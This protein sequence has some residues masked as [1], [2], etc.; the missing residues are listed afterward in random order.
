MDVAEDPA[1]LRRLEVRDRLRR[2]LDAL[3]HRMGTR[4]QELFHGIFV[5]EA[6]R[7]QIAR[8][9]QMTRGAVD[10]WCYRLRRIAR[11]IVHE[12]DQ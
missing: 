11:S 6:E 1:H 2:L 3:E 12:S 9:M 8:T 10:A 4:D 7:D 5:E